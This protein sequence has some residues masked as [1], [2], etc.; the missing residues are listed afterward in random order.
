MTY[1][2][3]IINKWRSNSQ[4]ESLLMSEDSGKDLASVQNLIKKHQLVEADI[5]AHED[6]IKDMNSQSDGLIES[7]QFDSDN[8][9]ERRDSI[10]ERYD[11]VKN[12]AAHRRDR[13]N[14]AN[15]LHQFFRDIADEESW[16]K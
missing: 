8:I 2:G 16:I 12:L 15:T 10:N 9:G 6:R 3:S 13:L 7:G 14:E 4:V 1:A 5:T 11:R